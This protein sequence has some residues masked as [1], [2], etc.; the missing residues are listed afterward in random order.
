MATAKKAAAKTA[1]KKPAPPAVTLT[2]HPEVVTVNP[3]KPGDVKLADQMHQNWACFAPAHY[4][5]EHLETPKFWTFMAP[6]FKD[7]DSIRITSEDGSWVAVG[8]I[9]RSQTMEVQVQIND[10]IQLQEQMIA[11]EIEI[12]GYLIKH[13]G[14]IRKFC[15]INRETKQVLK[16]NFQTQLQAMKYVTEHI[17]VQQMTG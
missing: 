6:K 8:Y 15:V 3:I 13:F 1:P 12:N 16:E 17:Q 2:P 9:R 4:T 5:Q 11:K 7:M 14:L 10:I